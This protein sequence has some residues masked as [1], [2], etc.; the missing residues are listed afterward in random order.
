[1]AIVGRLARVF[2]TRHETLPSRSADFSPQQ[3]PNACGCGLK[4]ALRP[5]KHEIS[6]LGMPSAFSPARVRCSA[7]TPRPSVH[8]RHPAGQVTAESIAEIKDKLASQ[9]WARRTYA[10][11]KAALAPWLAV[12]SE[13]L[14]QVFPTRRGNVYHNFSCPQDRCRLTFEPFESAQFKCPL[15][16]KTFPPETDAG[17]YAPGDRYHGSMYDGWACLFY[18]TAGG[19]AAAM[20]VAALRDRKVSRLILTRRAAEAEMTPW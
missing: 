9:D 7:P 13:K 15:C 5:R 1:M 3:L 6:G 8:W 12:S 16:G 17:I 2:H 4:S 19:L 20:G 10:A 18:E 14:R 11:Q